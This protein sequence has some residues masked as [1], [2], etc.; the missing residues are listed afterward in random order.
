MAE[1]MPRTH[2]PALL[3]MIF[4]YNYMNISTSIALAHQALDAVYA[5][6]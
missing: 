3:K 2:H 4:Y 1:V 6:D 5:N